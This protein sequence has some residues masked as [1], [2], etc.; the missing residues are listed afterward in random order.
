MILEK[1]PQQ[2]DSLL[3]ADL[4]P[5]VAVAPQ[6]FVKPVHG[7]RG[8]EAAPVLF[9]PLP[10]LPQGHARSEIPGD[11][12]PLTGRAKKRGLRLKR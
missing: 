1:L 12:I 10:V 4:R 5:E 8:R 2:L 3:P 6:D 11:L 7:F 9:E